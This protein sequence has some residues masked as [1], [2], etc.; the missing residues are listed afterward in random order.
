M[1]RHRRI[2]I[3]VASAVA[4][5]A[6]IVAV[7]IW[8]ADRTERQREAAVREALPVIRAAVG[9]TLDRY[10]REQIMDSLLSRASGDPDAYRQFI[11]IDRPDLLP[12]A[13]WGR[14]FEWDGKQYQWPD[15]PFTGEPMQP[16]KGP[17]DFSVT[18]IWYGYPS[19]LPDAFELTGYG[20]DG[21][22][23]ATVSTRPSP[24]PVQP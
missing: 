20:E 7:L 19:G 14:D 16:G 24:M 13:H 21:R 1:A 10:A 15:N 8:H 5:A 12:D 6:G 18:F 22:A 11:V 17:G 3:V 23:V 4:I 9:A 2:A